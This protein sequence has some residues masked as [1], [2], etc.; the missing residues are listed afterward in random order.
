MVEEMFDTVGFCAHDEGYG[1]KCVCGQLAQYE[2]QSVHQYPATVIN[3]LIY[4]ANG[5]NTREE[6]T[7][8]KNHQETQ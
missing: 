6:C 4:I 2:H 8:V 3:L 1:Q 5:S 7:R